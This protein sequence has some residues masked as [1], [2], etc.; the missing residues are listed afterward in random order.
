MVRT[1]IRIDSKLTLNLG[2]TYSYLSPNN[3]ELSQAQVKDGILA[4]NGPAWK[5]FVVQRDAN[6]TLDTVRFL[7]TYA[8]AGLP[9]IFTGGLPS[10]YPQG[11]STKDEFETEF[12]VLTGS[13]NVYS[14]GSGKV[15]STLSSLELRPNIA[16]ATNGTWF[17]TW[18]VVDGVD[19]AFVLADLSPSRGN[20]TIVSAQAPFFLNPWTGE[21]SPVLVYE[22]I[23]DTV[24]I[25]LSLA[26]NQT[27]IIAFGGHASWKSTDSTPKYHVASVPSNVLGSTFNKRG[28]ISLHVSQSTS[29][30]TA[31]HLNGTK[32]A[33]EA[34]SV[35]A[36]FELQE[37]SLTVEHW[38][39]PANL[40]DGGSPPAKLNS[41][42]KLTALAAW[43]DIPMLVNSSGVGYYTTSFSWPP[44]CSSSKVTDVSGA[45]IAFGAVSHGIRVKVNGS[46]L[47]P[48]DIT[49]AVADISTYLRTGTNTL[50]VVVPTTYW[51]YIR[52]IIGNLTEGYSTPLPVI[53]EGLLATPLAER[54]TTGLIGPVTVTPF[55]EVVL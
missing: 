14:V 30:A 55:K 46:P 53:L 40:S 3:L 25:P 28:G 15:A 17:T 27:V 54:D 39:A 52:T 47:P 21:S 48:L 9:V 11:N 49:N 29:L 2:W 31:T 42:Y 44:T 32:I 7:K 50:S 8:A 37:W 41:T 20:I 51:N 34:A 45:Y 10:F 35:P 12:S 6:V 33:L 16:V 36:L 23:D 19:Y 5:A 4:P 24:T 22:R 38:E 13:K 26:G 18:R 43:A 1:S